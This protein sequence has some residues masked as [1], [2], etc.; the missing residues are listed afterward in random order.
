MSV[1]LF[2]HVLT[3][4]VWAGCVFTE[5]VLE[6]VLEKQPPE[7]SHLAR[8][9]ALI[10]RYVEIP[11]II[12]VAATGVVLL[13]SAQWDTLLEVKV[14][15]GVTAVVLNSIAALTVQRRYQCLQSGNMSGY[16]YWNL[17]HERIGIGCVLSITGAIVVGGYRLVL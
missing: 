17:W 2:I 14:A 1:M 11:A 3:I 12:V 4:G 15:L 10:D 16:Q 13:Q 9:H 5:V 6:V 7:S 8:L